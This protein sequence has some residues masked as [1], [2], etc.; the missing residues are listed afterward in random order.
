M[1][2]NFKKSFLQN[3]SIAF[4]LQVINI[5]V[6]FI[7][8]TVFVKTLGNDYL[9]LNGLF[10]N[11]VSLL[12]FAELGI[13]NAIIFSL[14]EPIAM[15]NTEKINTLMH[16]FKK[17]YRWI[18]FI[19]A[20]LGICILPFINH[21]VNDVN[22]NEN[23]QILYI[24]FLINTYVS[25]FFAYKKS[26]L[27]A[28]QKNYIAAL[29]QQS[30]IVVQSVIQCIIILL[31]HNYV[32]YLWIQIIGTT[33]INIITSGYVDRHYKY[34]KQDASKL[35][36]REYLG[37]FENIKNIF[38]YK[39]GAVI[40]NSTDNILI[41]SLITTRYVG[42]YSNYSMIISALNG[43]L[44][45]V[46]NS[47]A[48]TI[49]IYNV[50]NDD[51]K[52]ESTFRYI[53]FISY[54][55][56]GVCTI[57][58]IELLNPFIS[59]WIGDTYLLN[60]STVVIISIVFYITG[61]NQIPSQ[62]RTS[63][64][65]FKQAKMIPLLASVINIILSIVLGKII[66]LNG[67]FIATIIAKLVTFNIMDPLLIYKNGF[68]K[69]SISFF[70]SKIKYFIV[71]VITFLGVHLINDFLHVEGILGFV[72]RGAITFCIT[73]LL[74][75]ILLYRDN[76]FKQLLRRGVKNGKS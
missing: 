29:I 2:K 65:I 24:L 23:F 27:I 5:L 36:K 38:C 71:L 63:F 42:L 60:F 46:C 40:L 53:F 25:Y 11:V 34:L 8:R 44:M 7:V 15:Q 6:T 17:A 26:L 18:R 56:F 43:V 72:V 19:I 51:E 28:D 75:A 70:Y 14:Y 57:C 66:G 20:I 49:G 35:D 3:A 74:L 30:I 33:M 10:T 58:L 16:L 64:G 50:Q 12:S 22:V 54:W 59:I 76:E 55:G 21:L 47:I 62:Y 68:K 9:S 13:G 67:I 32:L 61:I 52:N 73:N 69:E 37:I 48:A 31:F 41:S 1:E 4:I 45:Q 39:I